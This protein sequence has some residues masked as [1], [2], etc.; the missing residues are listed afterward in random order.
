VY[1]SDVNVLS[2]IQTAKEMGFITRIYRLAELDHG[3]I[4]AAEIMQKKAR[5]NTRR[6]KVQGRLNLALEVD[7][8]A[9]IQFLTVDT[10]ETIN[11]SF[12]VETIRLYIANG[13]NYMIAEGRSNG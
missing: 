5:Q 3:A 1:Y 6:Y 9:V 7:D 12:I 8:V 10:K 11:D 2:S 13:D 4:K